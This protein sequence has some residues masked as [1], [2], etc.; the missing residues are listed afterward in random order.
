M[1]EEAG[2]CPNY[3]KKIIGLT[4]IVS[5]VRYMFRKSHEL[6]RKFAEREGRSTRKKTHRRKGDSRVV[7][8]FQS[9]YNCSRSANNSFQTIYGMKRNIMEVEGRLNS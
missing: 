8:Y 5:V 2:N 7:L 4:I 6:T 3:Q 9:L 1:R